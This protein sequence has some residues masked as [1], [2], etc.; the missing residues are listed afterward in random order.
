MYAVIMAGG[1][2]TRLHPL[3]RPERPKPFLP[4]LD[5]RTLLQATA[6]RL[7]T[8]D[9][10]VV[11]DGRYERLVRDQLPDAAVLVEPMGR[12]TAAAIA[13]AAV[14]ID[15]PGD[16]VMLVVPADAHIDPAREATY[17]DVLRKA[18]EHLATGAFEVESPLVTLGTQMT[19]PSTDYGHL[20]PQ[21][22]RGA[23]IAGL[24]AYPLKAFE[25]KPKPPRAEE[26]FELTGVAWN[27]G[28]FL[29][30]RRA[31]R[32]A[33]ERFSSLVQLL[34][35]TIAAPPLL[36]HAYEQLK[37]ISIDY[38]VM[39]NAARNGEV[40]MGSMDVGWSDLGSWSAL[41]EGIGAR[42]TGAVVQPGETVTVEDDDL[43]VRRL[44]GRL[45][46]IAPLGRGSM[47][48]ER[49]IAV[50]RGAAA[51]RDRIDA[52]IER[53]SEGDRA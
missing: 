4:L 3:S 23:D 17:T 37:P 10:T 28:I 8:D 53:C 16:E 38:L 49:P 19:R 50:L 29:W 31:I 33:L 11:T 47:T 22:E 7:P 41:L 1:G 2:G 26:L 21:L 18:G 6:A 46:V 39:E 24:R 32:A 40:V 44:E 12:N 45:G 5:E 30:R 34:E 9:V 13:L 48:A 36:E 43:V 25:E 42:G 15:R 35:P 52:L 27:A 51:D 20:I 14:A